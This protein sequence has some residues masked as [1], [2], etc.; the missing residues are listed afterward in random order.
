MGSR[1]RGNDEVLDVHGVLHDNTGL[2]D[3]VILANAEIY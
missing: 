3:T 1:V 2:P